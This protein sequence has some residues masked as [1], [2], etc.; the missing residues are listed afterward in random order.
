MIRWLDLPHVVSQ[1]WTGLYLRIL[2]FV[3]AVGALVHVGNILGLTGVPWRETPPLWRLMDVVLLAFN[4]VVAVGLWQRHSW[5][6]V[7]LVGGVLALQVMP[8]TLFRNQ[9]VQR[10]EDAATLNGLL[11]TWAVLLAVLLVLVAAKR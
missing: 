7:A 2:A 10:A 1:P 5:A 4:V 8:Y 3:L 11:G 9:F 6:V